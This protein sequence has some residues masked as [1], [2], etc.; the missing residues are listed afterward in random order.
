M[1]PPATPSQF[2]I[3]IVRRSLHAGRSVE[4]DGLGKFR[5]I[6]GE[7]F[8]FLAETGRR[9][10]IA[11][12]VEDLQ[13]ARR[14]YRHLVAHGYC[15]WLDK[16]KLLPG[17]NWPRSIE[18]AIEVADFF[19]ACLSQRSV[20]KRGQFQSEIRY[21]LDCARKLPLDDVFFIPVRL[22]ECAV[23]PGIIDEIQYV[24]LF[25]DWDAGLER[26]LRAIEKAARERRTSGKL[27]G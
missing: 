8:E 10:F 23:P 14:L 13:Q 17:Q 9:V 4:I 16:E 11:Y 24:D 15:A 22:D 26:V 21:A 2:I 25:P 12:A 6:G 18:R 3:E 19:I 27:A 20:S 1:N 5:P 7:R